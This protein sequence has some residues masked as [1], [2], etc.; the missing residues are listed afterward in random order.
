M[1][2]K[3][4]LYQMNLTILNILSIII[5]IIV[6]LVSLLIDKGF[7]I[8][9][10]DYLYEHIILYFALYMIYIILHELLHSVSYVLYGA[11]FDKIEY[12]IEIEKGIL[13]CLCKQDISKR[14][15]LNSL[16]FPLFYIGIITWIISIIFKLPMLFLLS[17][18]NIMGCVGDIIMFLFIIKLDKN[19]KFSEYDD[20]TSFGIKTDKDISNI[21]HFGLKYLGT[22][23][24]LERNINKKINISKTSLIFIVII[25]LMTILSLIF[26]IFSI[27]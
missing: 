19:I 24:L 16:M 12:G 8:S 18:S 15:I 23:D 2:N 22:K 4:Y 9:S 27:N 14:N 7:V 26:K 11:K 6:S 20:S 17:I 21:N 5:L 25:I 1:K 3:Y 10:L 13:Y